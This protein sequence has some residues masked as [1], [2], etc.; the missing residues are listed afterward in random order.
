MSRCYCKDK[1]IKY[2]DHKTDSY[3]KIPNCTCEE[4]WDS[5]DFECS[6][7]EYCTERETYINETEICV[8]KIEHCF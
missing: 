1:W 2:Y 6:I 4:H 5:H 3:V 7:R 8:C